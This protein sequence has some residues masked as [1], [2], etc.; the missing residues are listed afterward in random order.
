M[1]AKELMRSRSPL[2]SGNFSLRFANHGTRPGAESIRRWEGLIRG[3]TTRFRQHFERV[4]QSTV[5]RGAA[6][7]TGRLQTMYF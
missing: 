4:R 5:F 3:N 1:Q 7:R 6:N 2:P